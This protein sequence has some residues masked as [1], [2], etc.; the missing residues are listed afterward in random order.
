M[1]SQSW[2]NG[3]IQ[4]EHNRELPAAV[5]RTRHSCI[6]PSCARA[7]FSKARNAFPLSIEII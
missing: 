6:N 5:A 3:P 7:C 2:R 4:A 1:A